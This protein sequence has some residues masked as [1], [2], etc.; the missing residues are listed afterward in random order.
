MI[1]LPADAVVIGLGGN[2]GDVRARFVDARA[3]LEQLGPLRS[4]PLYRTAPIGPAQADFLN[5]AVRITIIHATP[6]EVLSTVRELEML[7]GRDRS[8]EERWGPR[9]IDLD[10]LLWGNRTIHTPELEV[11]HPRWFE[12]RFVIEP[13]RALLGDDLVVGDRTLGA[14][15]AAV[16]DQDVEELAATW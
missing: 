12:R 13:L 9:T 15:A 1:A 16:A 3:A 11:P 4:A 6:H 10:I 5:T 2:V 8:R 7:L 14:C